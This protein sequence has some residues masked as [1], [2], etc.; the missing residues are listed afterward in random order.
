[1]L[2]LEIILVKSFKYLE[3]L[4][5]EYLL[6]SNR[7]FYNIIIW[8]VRDNVSNVVTSSNKLF[9]KYRLIEYY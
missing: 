5:I 7:I 3:I 6:F 4:S 2:L 8:A 1:M 9:I